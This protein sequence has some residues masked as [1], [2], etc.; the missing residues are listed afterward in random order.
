M[1]KRCAKKKIDIESGKLRIESYNVN[2]FL[3]TTY[4]QNAQK[5]N[6]DYAVPLFLASSWTSDDTQSKVIKVADLNIVP[7]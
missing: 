7:L 5:N 4:F 1:N 3:K 2:I 6:I